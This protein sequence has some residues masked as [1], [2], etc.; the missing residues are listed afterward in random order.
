LQM[1]SRAIPGEEKTVDPGLQTRMVRM[2]N[3]R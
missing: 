3:G 1:L 2:A